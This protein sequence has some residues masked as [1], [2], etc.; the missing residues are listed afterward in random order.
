MSGSTPRGT[1]PS[2]RRGLPHAVQQAAE[3][4]ALVTAA[5]LALLLFG[6][7]A[8]LVVTWLT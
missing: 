1:R 7:I 8:A 3:G 4:I 5:A 6:W 2:E